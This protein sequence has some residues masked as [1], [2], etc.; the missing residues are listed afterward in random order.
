MPEVQI[1][2]TA[3]LIKEDNVYI[4]IKKVSINA[5]DIISYMKSKGSTYSSYWTKIFTPDAS[6]DKLN[7]FLA[8]ELSD[9]EIKKFK[10]QH[11]M[12]SS[13]GVA[14]NND[15]GFEWITAQK[16]FVPYNPELLKDCVEKAIQT[17]LDK[18]YN[19]KYNDL[20]KVIAF[21]A[22]NSYYGSEYY[23]NTFTELSKKWSDKCLEIYNAK[24]AYLL[25][26]NDKLTNAVK[27]IKSYSNYIKNDIQKLLSSL[28]KTT[29]KSVITAL[30]DLQRTSNYL[31]DETKSF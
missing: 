4:V 9:D 19:I 17:V 1:D 30:Q 2:A 31:Y 11:T 26:E 20:E 15:G 28:P 12:S 29:P 27:S 10:F 23:V 18:P 25:I 24:R 14:P 16:V 21:E 8:N 6:V 7:S 3:Q 5:D 13:Y 22:S